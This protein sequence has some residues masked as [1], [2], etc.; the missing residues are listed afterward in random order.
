MSHLVIVGGGLAGAKVV[1][2]YRE[3]GGSDVHVEW[4]REGTT[5]MGRMAVRIITWT[6]GKPVRASVEK[7]L[8]KLEQLT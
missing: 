2:S 3:G 6:K 4:N 8:R 5:F 7:G 1:Q